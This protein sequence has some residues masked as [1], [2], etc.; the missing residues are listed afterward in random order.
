MFENLPFFNGLSSDERK[1][2]SSISTVRSYKSGEFLFM[3]G[4]EPRWLCYLISG[5]IRLY[6]S[7]PKGREIFMHQ[8]PPLNFVAELCN[9]ENIPYP[10]SAVF[11]LGGEV[12]KIDYEKFCE[13]ILKNPRISLA[14]IRSLSEKLKIAS[15]LLH[16]ELVL[17]SEAKVAKFIV[18][19]EDLFNSLKHT[20]IASILNIAPE[21]FSRILN[22]FKSSNLINLDENNQVLEKN[23]QF[24]SDF[25]QI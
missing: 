19:H 2:L 11:T 14:M 22:K 13:H 8:L 15:N 7:T 3:E 21:T 4:E 9:F 23:E 10:A 1:L 12:L 6:K 18:E 24:L 20:K 25:Y 16:Q 5:S 17:T